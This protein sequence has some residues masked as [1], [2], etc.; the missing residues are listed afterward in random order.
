MNE[1]EGSCAVVLSY[2]D[3]KK[4]S[5]ILSSLEVNTRLKIAQHMATMEGTSKEILNSVKTKFRNKAYI[6]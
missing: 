1:N 3:P 6:I 5:D 2:L 4:A